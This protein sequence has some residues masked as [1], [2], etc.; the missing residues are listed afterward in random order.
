[1]TAPTTLAV[2]RVLS[3]LGVK[4]GQLPELGLHSYQPVIIMG[5]FS[6]SLASE[7]VEARGFTAG[8]IDPF[9]IQRPHLQFQCVAGGGAVLETVILE[10][11]EGLGANILYIEVGSAPFISGAALN[12]HDIGGRP[13]RSLWT[14]DTVLGGPSGNE[15]TIQYPPNTVIDLS[16]LRWFVQPGQFVSFS[17]ANDD[18]LKFVMSWREMEEPIGVP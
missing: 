11:T 18:N 4:G 13:T 5:D 12:K 15:T 6:R 7:P 9:G 17:N 8:V 10:A 14:A 3:A 2:S 1:V 16:P